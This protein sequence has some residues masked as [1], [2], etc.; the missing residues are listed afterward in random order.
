MGKRFN[1]TAVIVL[2]LIMILTQLL[3][4]FAG[5]EAEPGL[6]N[7]NS[8]SEIRRIIG[9]GLDEDAESKEA[10]ESLTQRVMNAAEEKIAEEKQVLQAEAAST[11]GEG[12]AES[13]IVP[14]KIIVKYKAGTSSTAKS[15]LNSKVSAVS[16]RSFNKLGIT[17]LELPRGMDVHSAVSKLKDDPNIEYAEPVYVRNAFGSAGFDSN[18]VVESVYCT[19]PYYT[20]GWQWGLEALNLEDMWEDTTALQRSEVT[21]AVIDTGVD[22]DHDELKGSIVAGYD[23]INNDSNAD[24]DCG[25]GTHVAGIAAA[26]HDGKGIAGVAGGTKIMPVKVLDEYGSGSTAT[27]INGILYAVN[28]GADVINLS[29]G[30]SWDSIAEKEAIDYALSRGVTVVAAAGNNYGG[31]VSYP[32]AYDGVIA[33]GA[34]DWDG[35]TGKFTIADFSNSGSE[36]DILAPGVDILS[37]IPEE[38]DNPGN[39]TFT[40]MGDETQDGY[41]IADGTS[42]ASPFAAGM[43][44]LLLAGGTD[45]NDVLQ[46]MQDMGE[47]FSGGLCVLNSGSGINP[48]FS[49]RHAVL[50]DTYS[51]IN[52]TYQFDLSFEDYKGTVTDAVYGT[53]NLMMGEYSYVNGFEWTVQ[54]RMVSEIKIEEGQSHE[55][56]TVEIAET[57]KKYAFYVEGPLGYMDSNPICIVQDNSKSFDEA[58]MLQL[59]AETDAYLDFAG[60]EDYFEFTVGSEEAGYYVIESTGELDTYGCLYDADKMEIAHDDDSG[61]Y[62]NFRIGGERSYNCRALSPG[63][64]YVM[65]RG[66]DTKSGSYGIIVRKLKTI[67]GTISLPNGITASDHLSINVGLIERLWSDASKKYYYYYGNYV[68]VNIPAGR[69]TAN[70]EII[71]NSG[72]SYFVEYRT[73]YSIENYASVGYYSGTRTVTTI[74]RSI[75]VAAGAKNINIT[76]IPISTVDDNER[77][78]FEDADRAAQLKLGEALNGIMHFSGDIDIYKLSVTKEGSYAIGTITDFKT[79]SMMYP[80]ILFDSEGYSIYN[81]GHIS[82]YGEDGLYIYGIYNLSPG[83]YY[84]AA[85][86]YNEPFNV[87]N[88]KVLAKEVSII[89]G[90]VS[91]PVEMAAS[92]FFDIEIIAEDRQ[93]IRYD[94]YCCTD[95]I[96][97]IGS[98]GYSI[99]YAIG[100]PPS[101]GY[102]MSY[103]FNDYD[104]E[105]VQYADEGFYSTSGTKTY[106]AFATPVNASTSISGINMEIISAVDSGGSSMETATQ[107]NIDTLVEGRINSTD[108]VDYFKFTVPQGGGYYCIENESEEYVA[109]YLKT[110][111]DWIRYDEGYGSSMYGF[112]SEGDYYLKIRA[113][114]TNYGDYYFEVRSLHKPTAANVAISGTASVDS[115]LTGSYTYSDSDGDSEAG[116]TYRWLRG[117]TASGTYAAVSGATAKTYTLTQSDLGKYIKFEVTPKADSEPA[118]GKAAISGAIGPVQAASTNT[119]NNGGSSGGGGGGGGGS[120]DTISEQTGAGSAEVSKAA[121]GRTTVE[122]KVDSSKVNST[123]TAA[124]NTPV[125]LDVKTTAD[126]DKLNVNIPSDIFSKAAE[127][128][129]QVVVNS[130]NVGF[131]IEPGTFN[132]GSLNGEVKLEVSQLAADSIKDIV[133]NKDAAANEVSLVFDFDLSIGDKKIT[134]FDKPITITVKFDASKVTDLS[135]VGVYYYNEKGGTW[136]YVGGKANPDGTITF[137][138]EHFS[139]YTAMEYKK[140]FNDIKDHWAKA[141]I[142]LLISKHIV[143]SES[144][145]GF[146]PDSSITRAVFASM[147]VKALDIKGVKTDK[148]FGDITTDAWYKEDV[149]KAYAA[150]IINGVSSKDFAPDEF[151]TR[152]QMATMLMRAYE[153][154]TGKKLEEIVTTMNIRFT[155]ESSISSWA[156]KNVV[157]ANAT[158]LV[159]GNPDGKYNP[160]GNMTKAQAATVI[161]RLMEKL[162]RL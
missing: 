123:L 101:D 43:A 145:T 55:T 73:G 137:T 6:T 143:R 4:V 70:Y 45:Y 124:G 77:N 158:G 126:Q 72:S 148:V 58:Q 128:Q 99:A 129:K 67:S 111:E 132:A 91:L 150:G 37:T 103:Y 114:D 83:D 19:E 16:S 9:E 116:S 8:E 113:E 82:S 108:D 97:S 154:A 155:D 48:P 14:D 135:K 1:K 118:T 56:T 68:V 5:S 15:A 134:E 38:L 119:N 60:D 41:F 23:F 90:A 3:T 31:S 17:Q 147:V 13:G 53:F 76:L 75:Q 49:F 115:T 93:G 65:V 133:K 130:N 35:A 69:S 42:M 142:E 161:K 107:I 7:V 149:Y 22:V 156:R 120:N 136:E 127:A 59:N 46:E 47:P 112:F 20:K 157:L 63:K 110:E 104:G 125:I 88:Y 84:Y 61:D 24:D 32:A 121:D 18:S 131:T 89:S 25:H 30:S 78:T 146:A 139:K 87:F 79:I 40:G 51:D 11:D 33:V 162:N 98:S 66:Y 29:L 159:A 54:P 27:V 57:D 71:S 152:E 151:I 74:D 94:T 2:A 62:L 12:R 138:V 109:I 122:V 34:A 86:G 95:E 96:G 144:E 44:A 64:Y 36:L 85:Y 141:D 28:N 92:N 80:G 117:D 10:G 50:S 140:T 106:A 52:E 26:A 21:I 81:S 105:Y 39:R 160:K 153:Y 102:I 100:V